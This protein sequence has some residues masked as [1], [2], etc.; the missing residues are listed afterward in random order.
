M[1]GDLISDG[2]G[3]GGESQRDGGG[4]KGGWQIEGK[5][6]CVGP[7]TGSLAVWG[8]YKRAEGNCREVLDWV[9]GMGVVQVE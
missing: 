9:G 3:R 2:P 4:E 6:F 8:R 5:Y 7:A 1:R